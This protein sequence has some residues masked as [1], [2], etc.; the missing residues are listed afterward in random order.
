MAGWVWLESLRGLTSWNA[1]LCGFPNDEN[2]REDG[3]ELSRGGP[4]RVNPTWGVVSEGVH[5]TS[6]VGD[7]RG[8]SIVGGLPTPIS[9]LCGGAVLTGEVIALGRNRDNEVLAS[10]TIWTGERSIDASFRVSLEEVVDSSS[11]SLSPLEEVPLEEE[12][13]GSTPCVDVGSVT[14]VRGGGDVWLVMM[15]SADSWSSCWAWC[16]VTTPSDVTCSPVGGRGSDT[17]SD[18]TGDLTLLGRVVALVTLVTDRA[19]ITVLAIFTAAP[20]FTFFVCL[21]VGLVLMD[22]AL[23]MDCR[24]GSEGRVEGVGVPEDFRGMR[25]EGCKQGENNNKPWI[26][27]YN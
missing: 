11:E 4:N 16:V 26:I 13:D 14:F 25:G 24:D 15:G 27:V 18:T 10:A 9:I 23:E 8:D 7:M 20:W 17:T 22:A 21:L 1:L 19:L 12:L 3:G 2:G 5:W 6:P